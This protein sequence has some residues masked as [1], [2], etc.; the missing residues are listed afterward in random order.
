MNT[1]YYGDCLTIMQQEMKAGSVD[2]IYLD[3]PF[4][5]NRAY[6]AIYKD[7]TGRPLPDQIEAFC[8]M[9][10]LDEERN[11]A[12]RSLP[13]LMLQKGID[14]EV[15]EFWQTW[16]NALRK[17]NDKLLA[18]LSY[19]VERIVQMKIVLKPTGS[20]YLHCDP[21]CSHYIKVMMDGVF[22]QKNFRNEITW[23]YK[24]MASKNQRVFNRTHDVIL[25]YS[26]SH[27]WV[28]NVDA[29]RLPYSESSKKRAGYSK[30]SLGGGAP[31]S[32]ICELNSK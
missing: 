1:L 3:P 22:G 12:I 6:N 19:M 23:C 28:F 31:N 8:D 7:E 18:Y 9:W 21:T 20:I 14:P 29:V 26:K 2:L 15:V 13:E 10:T 30:S 5:S 32:G 17:T 24:R 4:N 27:Q 11:R 25:F 16:M